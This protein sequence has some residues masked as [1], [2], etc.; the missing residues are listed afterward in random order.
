MHQL[1]SQFLFCYSVT[2][3]SQWK[4]Q[5]ALP[6]C[7]GIE[8]DLHSD[9]LVTNHLTND[10]FNNPPYYQHFPNNLCNHVEGI[11]QE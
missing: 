2:E 1:F 7:F 8:P 6:H 11:G 10:I 5:I 4:P 3:R 9:R